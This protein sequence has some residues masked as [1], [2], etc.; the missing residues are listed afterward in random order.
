MYDSI[1]S[2]NVYNSFVNLFID[3]NVEEVE[4]MS[5]GIVLQKCYTPKISM[6][7]HCMENIDIFNEEQLA[8]LQEMINS[9]K[10]L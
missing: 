9:Y 10:T 8:N 2:D 6:L 7:I 5:F 1:V 4:L 3:K